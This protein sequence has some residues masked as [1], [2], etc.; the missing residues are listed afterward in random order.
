M[1]QQ[2]LDSSTR[3]VINRVNDIISLGHGVLEI[4]GIL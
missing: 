1:F 2:I 4:I 3:C